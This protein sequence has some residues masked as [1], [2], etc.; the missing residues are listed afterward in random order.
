MSATRK[1][2]PE[3]LAAINRE[4]GRL[5]PDLVA[6]QEVVQTAD[7][8]FLDTLPIV[9]IACNASSLVVDLEVGKDG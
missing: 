8:K 4:L 5:D 3:R 7:V 1:G 6:F 2:E 9:W